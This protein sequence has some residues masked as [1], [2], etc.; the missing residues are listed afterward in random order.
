MSRTTTM[1]QHPITYTIDGATFESEFVLNGPP[2]DAQTLLLLAPNLFGLGD[3]ARARGEIFAKPGRDVFLIDIYG[4]DRRPGSFEDALGPM[5]HLEANPAEVRKRMLAAIGAARA[6]FQ[7]RHG[8][9]P[10]REVAIGFCFGGGNVLELAR[11]GAKLDAI[12]SIHGAL[13][14]K[15]PAAKGDICSPVYIAHGAADPLI[16]KPH[17]DTVEQELTEAG[18]DWSMLIFGGVLHAYTDAG[19]PATEVSAFDA[20][21]TDATYRLIEELMG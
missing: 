2:S 9:M 20:K 13:V 16:P 7:Q 6:D 19:I 5:Q 12:V 10:K 17:R 11:A 18:A 1:T 21:A 3:Q 14:S 8:H 15:A 4:K